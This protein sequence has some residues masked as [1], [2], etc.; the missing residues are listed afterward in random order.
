MFNKI[1]IANRG[2]IATRIIR[3]CQEMGIATVAV[4]STADSDALHVSL[5]DEAVCIGEPQSKDSYLDM[6]AILSAAY[7][8]GAQ[9]IHPGFGF[10]SENSKFA[11]LCEAMNITFIG[12]HPDVIDRMGDKEHARKTMQAANVPT[13]PG[14]KG[15]IETVADGLEVAEQVGYPVLLKATAGGGG[16][17]MRLVETPDAFQKQY[18]EA[19]REAKQAFGNDQLY[20]EKVIHPA[21]HIEVQVLGDNFGNVIHLG[22]RECSLQRHHQKV[23]EETPSP[24]INEDTRVA[25]CNAAVQATKQVEYTG[26]GTIEFLVDHDQ[27]FYFMEMNTRVQVEH[28]ITEMITGVDIVREQIRIAENEPLSYTQEEIKISG[29]AMECRINAEQPENLFLPSMGTFEFVHFPM[30]NLGLRVE[31]A[32]YPGYKMPPFYDNMIAK[33]ITHGTTR[34]EM[35]AKM[36]RSIQ[37]LYIRGVQTNQQMQYDLLHDEAFAEGNYTIDYLETHFLPQWLEQINKEQ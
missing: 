1:L 4:Y 28:P 12:P 21:H 25:I 34:E 27:N 13:T 6:Q 30:G 36:D 19:K 5:A 11:K 9:A 35:I 8:T 16:K 15:F 24:F 10:L 29:H 31:S 20:L 37:E 33:I 26:A 32:I 2:E 3:T 17:G 22:E 14:S 23:L 18:D 7:V